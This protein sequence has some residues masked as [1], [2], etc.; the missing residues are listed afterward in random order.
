MRKSIKRMLVPVLCAAV[1]A[2]L[3]LVGCSSGGSN[4]SSASSD[5]GIQIFAANS[6]EKALPEVQDL[7]TQQHPDAKFAD[8]QF[9]ASGTLVQK[10]K[11]GGSADLLICASSKTMDQAVAN[12]N[13]DDATR[14]D[15]F[16]NDLVIATKDGSNLKVKNIKDLATN[17]DIKSIAIGEPN[18]VPA[19][20]YAIQALKS[21]G[22]VTYDEADDG[23]I[24]N[25]A[26]DKSIKD[27]INAGADKVGTV[28]SYVADGTCTVGFVYTSDI[29]R[30]DGIKVAYTT[31]AKSHKNI[32]Y[33]GA[34]VKDAAHADQAKDFLN[35]CLTD[36]DAQKIFSKYGFELAD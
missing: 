23:T 31:P 15:M 2:A 6:L 19:G 16:N 13:I 10:L 3:A 36:A 20:K 32:V 12:G 27:K 24:S 17:D 29:Y 14:T 21:A 22:L 30:Y 5:G 26:W 1:V 25:I 11:D 33:P 9:E 28:A 34:V 8:T 35:F 7:Y 18:T 4:S